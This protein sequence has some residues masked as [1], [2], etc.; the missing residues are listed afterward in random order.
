MI[1]LCF[2]IVGK[3]IVA[4]SIL[5]KIILIAILRICEFCIDDDYIWY[6]DNYEEKM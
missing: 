1:T 5:K 2:D 4:Y 3:Y 6:C